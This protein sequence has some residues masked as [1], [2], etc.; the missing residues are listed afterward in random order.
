[1]NIPVTVE[2]AKQLE[3]KI[4]ANREAGDWVES[5]FPLSGISKPETNAQHF[6]IRGEAIVSDLLKRN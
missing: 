1:M 3:E 6:A 2:D 4:A 5:V